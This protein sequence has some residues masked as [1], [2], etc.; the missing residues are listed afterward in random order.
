MRALERAGKK[1][2]PRS[3]LVPSRKREIDQILKGLLAE[4]RIIRFGE[5]SK[6]V[7][8]SKDFAPTCQEA[9][10]A[11]ARGA[12]QFPTELF[13]EKELGSF[14]SGAQRLLLKEAVK[15]LVETGILCRLK[16]RKSFYYV[17][18]DGIALGLG[19]R[20]ACFDP[21][22]VVQVYQELVTARGFLY[23]R[24]AELA[25]KAQVPLEPLQAWLLEQ[26]SM[27]KAHLSRGDWSLATQEERRAA[28]YLDGQP[29]LLVRLES[30]P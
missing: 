24:I 22:K 29:H 23:V 4:G 1:G 30:Q 10:E 21:N 14:C 18:R 19:Q 9:A 16:R 15:H 27:G 11:I 7:Y 26:S 2:L 5:R 6:A 28:I 8:F 3:R 12:A 13:L 25:W 20:Q 17:H